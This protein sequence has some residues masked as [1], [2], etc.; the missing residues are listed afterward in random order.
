MFT[1][2]RLPALKE[3]MHDPLEEFLVSCGH[4]A[5]VI[6]DDV[7]FTAQIHYLSYISLS[8]SGRLSLS[9]KNALTID[10]FDMSNWYMTCP[11]IYNWWLMHDVSCARP[12]TETQ[13]HD[14]TS[15]VF[16]VSTDF[17]STKVVELTSHPHSMTRH[18]NTCGGTHN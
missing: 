7:D 13:L 15:S 16:T 2:R 1:W 10:S 11:V 5:L 4:V 14:A 6:A 17:R 9:M 3:T 12:A 8:Q 18:K